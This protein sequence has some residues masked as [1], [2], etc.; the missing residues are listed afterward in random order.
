MDAV[1][2]TTKFDKKSNM[3]GV[4]EINKGGKKFILFY[5]LGND[6]G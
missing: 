4:V 5:Y 1:D 2:V 6:I 3:A